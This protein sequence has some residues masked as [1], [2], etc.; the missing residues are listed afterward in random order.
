MSIKS[1]KAY[2]STME[3]WVRDVADKVN[4]LILHNNGETSVTR[5]NANYTVADND[6]FLLC[7]TAGVTIPLAGVLAV[8]RK[9]LINDGAGG[10]TASPIT[11]NGT[12]DGGSSASISTDYDSLTLRSDGIQWWVVS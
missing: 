7:E 6:T 3:L 9:I 5:V 8:G 10:A 2:T 11:V 4:R 1:L 12:I